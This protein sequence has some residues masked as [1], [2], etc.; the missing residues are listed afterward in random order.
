MPLESDRIDL[1][2]DLLTGD[3][4]VTTD[5]QFSTGLEA[6]AQGIRQRLLLFAEEWFLNLEVGVPWFQEILGRKF[7]EDRARPA[8]RDAILRTPA[9]AELVDLALNFDPETRILDVRWRAR[10]E[11]D[12]S[13]TTLLDGIAIPV[14][15]LAA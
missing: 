5:I 11:F 1:K 4:I 13:S 14:E 6:V 3:L 2:T 10:V 9:V 8:F 12:D 15:Q 7:N